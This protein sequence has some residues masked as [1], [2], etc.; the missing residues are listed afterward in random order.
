MCAF[1]LGT[2]TLL[3]CAE[4]RLLPT[5]FIWFEKRPICNF[6]GTRLRENWGGADYSKVCLMLEFT[7]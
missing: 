5:T 6:Y 4:T 2:R 7:N 3:E 1:N